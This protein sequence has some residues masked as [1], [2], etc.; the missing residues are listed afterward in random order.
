[1]AANPMD[2]AK[3]LQRRYTARATLA[4]H[5]SFDPEFI[6]ENLPAMWLLATLYFRA[7]VRGFENVPDAPTLLVGNHNGGIVIPDTWITGLGWYAYFGV[8]R[9]MRPLVHSAAISLPFVGELLRKNGCMPASPSN[10]REAIQRGEDVLV[11]PGGD[12]ETWRPWSKRNQIDFD[13]R[14]GF[15]RLAAEEGVPI[16]P[17]VSIGAH[18]T[19]AVLTDGK[20]LAKRLGVDK[21]FRLKVFPITVGLPFGI[22]PGVLPH[23]PFPSKIVIDVLPPIE[24]TKADVSDAKVKKTYDHVTTTFQKALDKLTR[25]RKRPILG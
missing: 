8:E 2:L 21:R 11:Y 12:V 6:R 9:P 17:V 22:F 23:F 15:L 19:F 14:T 3:R 4:D 5:E 10:A 1:M 13:G 20:D 16:V 25:E 24:I 18:E 7:E